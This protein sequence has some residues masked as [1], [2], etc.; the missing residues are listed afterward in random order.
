MNDTFEEVPWP[1]IR[2]LVVDALTAGHR[3]HLAHGLLE[4]DVSRALALLQEDKARTPG[5]TS[6]TAFLA[7][8]LGQ[9]VDRHKML[10]AYR[11][12]SGKLVIFDDVDVSTLLEKR[13]PDGSLVPVMYVVRGANRKTLTDINREMRDAVRDDLYDEPGVRRRRQILR[14]PRAARRVLWWWMRRDPVRRK[15]QW[16]TVGLSNAGSFIGQRP[17]WGIPI[18]FVT[19]AL[20]I[21]SVAERVC[22]VDGRPQPRKMLGVT[23]TVDHDIVDGAPGARFA[24]TLAELIESAAGLADLVPEQAPAD[25][26]VR[27]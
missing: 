7:Y 17:S 21:G 22:W 1:R 25:A 13:K 9:A 2:E 20:I 11:K 23:V 27:P 24:R 16:G 26:G 4:I 18:S 10:H 5:A 15:R 19:C 12:G 8:C 6:F 3:A 14:L